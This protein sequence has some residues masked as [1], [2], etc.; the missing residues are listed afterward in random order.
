[1]FFFFYLFVHCNKIHSYCFGLIIYFTKTARKHCFLSGNIFVLHSIFDLQKYQGR[2]WL[3]TSVPLFS[4]EWEL[5]APGSP[6]EQQQ[7]S[8][9]SS[10]VSRRRPSEWDGQGCSAHLD[11]GGGTSLLHTLKTR[12][13]RVHLNHNNDCLFF[14]RSPHCQIWLF[15]SYIIF[16]MNRLS[17]KRL[18]L[19]SGRENVRRAERR[20]WKWGTNLVLF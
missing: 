11:Q 10:S 5:R 1:M 17:L 4:T 8:W 14:S 2:S 9:V 18:R 3:G 7:G 20:L 16:F 13:G 19:L 12:E 6:T 15:S